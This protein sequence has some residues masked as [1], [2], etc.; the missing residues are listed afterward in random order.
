MLNVIAKTEQTVTANQNVIFNDTRVKSRRCGCSSGWLNHVKGSGLFTIT[1]RTN[2]PMAVEVEFNGN[3]TAAA[4]GATALVIELNGEAIG[5]TEMDY[6]VVTAN[7]YQNVG[8]ST[9]IP[10][11]A[12]SSITVSIGNISAGEV[13][14]KDANIIIKKLA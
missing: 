11:P 14:V 10:V 12:G 6:T 5:G 3:V 1:N 8:A 9:L 7:T 4:A 2:L 13:L